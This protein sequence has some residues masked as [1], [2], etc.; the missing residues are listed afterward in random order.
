[1]VHHHYGK[2]IYV[3]I[4]ENTLNFTKQIINL[5]TIKMENKK[6]WT[7]EQVEFVLE[8][9]VIN[10]NKCVNVAGHSLGSIKALLKNI[11][12]DYTGKGLANGNPMY[13]E[14]CTKFRLKNNMS[15]DKFIALYF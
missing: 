15:I 1:V 13:T 14:V 7:K 6:K 2:Q 9:Y 10:P 11:S 5:K 3:Q 12:Y 4:V 8:N